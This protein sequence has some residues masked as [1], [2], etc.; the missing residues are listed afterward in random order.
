MNKFKIKEKFHCFTYNNII[1]L[2][3][4]NTY[5]CKEIIMSK[6]LIYLVK[7]SESTIG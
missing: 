4:Q 5:F 3:R 7:Y 6:P 2:F 1:L